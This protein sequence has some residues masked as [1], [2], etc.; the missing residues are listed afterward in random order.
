ML[1][2][3]L[4]IVVALAVIIGLMRLT[5]AKP[6]DVGAATQDAI[7]STGEA[8]EDAAPLAGDAVEGAADA[9]MDATDEAL[10]AAADVID[11]AG[12]VVEDVLADPETAV[13]GDDVL[14]ADDA[15]AEEVGA[16]DS[17]TEQPN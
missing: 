13:E 5:G 12:D 2:I 1:R 9:A 11:E 8:I 7:E 15:P 4:I 10:D 3:L 6:G 17:S 16:D 14:S